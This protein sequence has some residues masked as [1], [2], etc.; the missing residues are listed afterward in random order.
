MVAIFLHHLGLTWMPQGNLILEL[1]VSFVAN[2]MNIFFT[3]GY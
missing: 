3:A 1:L 2:F